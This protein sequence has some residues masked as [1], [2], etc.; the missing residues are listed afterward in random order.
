ME[1]PIRQRL[2]TVRQSVLKLHKALIESERQ[3]YEQALG[4][5]QSPNH[6]LQLVTSDPW[7]AWLQPLSQLIVSI[8]EANDSEI[9]LTAVQVDAFVREVGQLLTPSEAG[10]GF[11]RHYHEA[12]QRDPNVVLAHGELMKVLGKRKPKTEPR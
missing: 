11:A 10:E 2:E 1:T 9:P 12:M 7:F 6:F 4:R 3:T 5:I 8:D